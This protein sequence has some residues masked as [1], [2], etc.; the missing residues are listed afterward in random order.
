[1]SRARDTL[2]PDADSPLDLDRRGVAHTMRPLSAAPE[3][4]RRPPAALDLLTLALLPRLAP[5]A[6]RK[7]CDRGPIADVLA[8]PDAH[9]HLL[10]AE[11]LALLRRAGE[12]ERRTD[13]ERR[14][15]AALGVQIVARDEPAFPALVKEIFDPP[16][17]LWV[18]GRLQAEDAE[19]GVAIVGAR[20]ATPAG[21]SLARAMSSDLAAAGAT[22]VS[23]LARGIDTAAHLGALDGGGRT[24]AVLGCGVDRIYPP[25]NAALAGR[26]EATGAVVS[27][28][29]LGTPPLPH[30]F[31]QRNRIIAGWSR[32]VVVVEAAAR[33]GALNTA[34]TAA[35]ENR[36]VMA[37]PGHP[38]QPACEGTNQLLR[39]GAAFVRDARDVAA[40]L[41][42][43]LPAENAQAV[44]DPVLGALRRDA[45]LS[46]EDLRARSGLET[47]DLLARLSQLEL[48]DA[49]R[50]LPGALFVR[51]H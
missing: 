22:I 32:G 37:V 14:R 43:E 8:D 19:R 39:D 50:R 47:P 40:E 4:E 1:M 44:A 28:F 20:A 49:V 6:V 33:S 24:V 26:I 45:P 17:V 36:D 15:A 5:P 27:E 48:R 2:C 23:G 41:G 21:R 29:P 30:H 18:R 38:S 42:F 51:H 7:L 35:D 3:G 34:R 11:A 25:E 12:A 46:L 10:S 31:P 9:A 13:E 16:P